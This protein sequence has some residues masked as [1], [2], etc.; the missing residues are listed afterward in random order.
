MVDAEK[1]R[2]RHLDRMTLEARTF[3][4]QRLGEGELADGVPQTLRLH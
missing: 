4:E 3:V 2:D 1:Q